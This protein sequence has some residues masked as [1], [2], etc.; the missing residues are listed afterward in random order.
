MEPIRTKKK[1][2]E[3]IGDRLFLNKKMTKKNVHSEINMCFKTKKTTIWRNVL[4]I[5]SPQ[6][7]I[8][9]TQVILEACDSSTTVTFM[10]HRSLRLECFLELSLNGQFA[11]ILSGV[12]KQFRHFQ[13]SFSD[14]VCKQL[15]T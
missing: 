2:S 14:C 10:L 4:I 7:V 5:A 13:M 15:K 11:F 12:I 9:Y 1:I 8:H 6:E 3:F